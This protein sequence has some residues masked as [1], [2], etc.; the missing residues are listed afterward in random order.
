MKKRVRDPNKVREYNQRYRA[1]NR[2]ALNEKAREYYHDVAK[3]N[4][5]KPRSDRDTILY[6]MFSATEELVYVGITYD[7]ARRLSEHRRRSTWFPEVARWDTEAYGERRL[8]KDVESE[9][10]K[11]ER[12][13][14]NRHES[15]ED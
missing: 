13:K 6:R 11:R 7:F 3:P 9:I 2:E 8:A 5:P 12:P 10:I 1:K 14:F 4:R 15:L